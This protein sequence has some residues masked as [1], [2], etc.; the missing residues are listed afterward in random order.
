M[1]SADLALVRPGPPGPRAVA[2][3][4]NQVVNKRAAR[5]VAA[6]QTSHGLFALALVWSGGRV[7]QH[8]HTHELCDCGDDAENEDHDKHYRQQ[9]ERR[10]V[11]PEP[12]R[13]V[14]AV[15]GREKGQ[16]C[17]RAGGEKGGEKG[18]VRGAGP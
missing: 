17:A 6:E 18:A 13:Y 12:V 15:R 9:Y 8:A 2:R 5:P 3:E 4:D 10:P 16:G 11:P 1:L 14:P 7:A